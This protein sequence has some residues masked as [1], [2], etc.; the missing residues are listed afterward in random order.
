ML[1]SLWSLWIK[2]ERMDCQ[3]KEIKRRLLDSY[4]ARN[5]SAHFVCIK[6]T[7]LYID[8]Y[9]IE[10]IICACPE[11][12]VSHPT[13]HLWPGFQHCSLSNNATLP[14]LHKNNMYMLSL[15]DLPDGHAHGVRLS[16]PG[17]RYVFLEDETVRRQYSLEC[18]LTQFWIW[19]SNCVL[20]NHCII[21][22]KWDIY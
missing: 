19:N 21:L 18:R 14:N 11:F 5:L 22:L 3:W 2:Q 15:G 4:N 6:G 10:K 8:Y 13:I 20:Y 16:V 7:T 12:S 17:T 1:H 9:C